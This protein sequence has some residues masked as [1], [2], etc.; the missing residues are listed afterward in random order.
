MKKYI[1]ILILFLPLF[2]LA[3][4][5]LKISKNK[6]NNF[7][8][9]QS[10]ITENQDFDENNSEKENILNT[11]QEIETI[12]ETS[13]K[14]IIEEAEIIPEEKIINTPESK[15]MI[16]PLYSYPGSNGKLS[17]IWQKL[18]NYKKEYSDIDIIAIIPKE[19]LAIYSDQLREAGITVIPYV[20]GAYSTESVEEIKEKINNWYKTH[21]IDGIFLDGVWNK[22]KITGNIQKI[23]NKNIIGPEIEWNDHYKDYQIEIN[24]ENRKI[25]STNY[26]TQEIEI[27]KKFNNVK[28]GDTFYLKP[29]IEGE[30]KYATKDPI[31]Y[32]LEIK[33]YIKTINNDAIFILNTGVRVDQDFF[34]NNIADYIIIHETNKIPT[35]QEMINGYGDNWVDPKDL[36]Y[37]KIGIL[38][39]SQNTFDEE[40]FKNLL[41]YYNIHYITDDNMS[42]R[43]PWDT[44]SSYMGDML[45][46]YKEFKK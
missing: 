42:D 9:Y 17:E 11:E 26:Y 40:L 21:K 27:D 38:I 36:Q 1:I 46:L 23:D 4:Y 6:N 16:I 3:Y 20:W 45:K 25:I 43:N 8:N 5:E 22:T 19:G 35:L 24:G 2:S 13:E 37:N 29:Y 28:I 15:K 34:D 39:H 12:N 44:L 41:K 30:K 14:K 18:V 31:K 7:L 33:N 32:Y 10:S